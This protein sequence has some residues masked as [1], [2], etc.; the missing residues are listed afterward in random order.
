[1]AIVTIRRVQRLVTFS[2]D[3]TIDRSAFSNGHWSGTYPV[4]SWP[5]V[6]T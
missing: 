5:D 1:M 3:N 2:K 6:A 4:Y